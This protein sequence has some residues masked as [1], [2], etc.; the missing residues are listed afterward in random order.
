MKSLRQRWGFTPSVLGDFLVF[1]SRKIQ[2]TLNISPGSGSDERRV[3]GMRGLFVSE[4][5]DELVGGVKWCFSE[6]IE[7]GKLVSQRMVLL[8]TLQTLQ[9]NQ[10]HLSNFPRR[11]Q[12]NN[13]GSNIDTGTF[14]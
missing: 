4:D 5:V 6:D 3:V 11:D 13:Q 8:R 2:F 12:I 9:Q 7:V 14:L 10:I 1:W